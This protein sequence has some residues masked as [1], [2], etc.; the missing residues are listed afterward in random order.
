MS[1][2]SQLQAPFLP[3]RQ[4]SPYQPLTNTI[5]RWASREMHGVIAQKK[6]NKLSRDSQSGPSTAT[7][8]PAS[9]SPKKTKPASSSLFTNQQRRRT[10]PAS[11]KLAMR[12]QESSN[13]STESSEDG[14][15]E[16]DDDESAVI[17]PT[18]TRRKLSE[19]ETFQ[20]LSNPKRVHHGKRKS[21]PAALRA[22]QSFSKFTNSDS[23]SGSTASSSG[24]ESD[25]E[26]QRKNTPVPPPPSFTA[27]LQRQKQLREQ[28]QRRSSALANDNNRGEKDQQRRESRGQMNRMQSEAATRGTETP[29]SQNKGKET[30]VQGSASTQGLTS[31]VRSGTRQRRPAIKLEEAMRIEKG[32]EEWSEDT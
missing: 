25:V 30:Q 20:Q 2:C 6:A 27:R 15:D 12:D 11:S 19:Y 26:P 32:G 17:S 21:R 18:L 3:K 22:S 13:N 16:A 7:A 31:A 24:S 23:R 4:L 10:I 14:D 9:A 29:M 1:Q 28:Q 8:A 5:G